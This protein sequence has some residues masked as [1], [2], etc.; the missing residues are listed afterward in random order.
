MNVHAV[1]S[2]V[3]EPHDAAKCGT[4]AVVAAA[5]AA[6]ATAA[7]ASCEE[8]CPSAARHLPDVLSVLY[9]LIPDSEQ[10]KK[11]EI[12]KSFYVLYDQFHVYAPEIRVFIWCK[13]CALLE[14]IHLCFTTK[15]PS[16]PPPGPLA[17]VEDATNPP[18]GALAGSARQE[19]T[20]FCHQQQWTQQLL[21]VSARKI[22]HRLYLA[23]ARDIGEIEEIRVHGQER[24][25]IRNHIRSLQTAMFGDE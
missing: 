2:L 25:D 13:L 14:H 9:H 10:D 5:V 17:R 1:D 12:G 18:V 16:P 7:T 19:P 4:A 20:G 8:S 22:D 11:I 24:R 6:T 21:E 3:I 15:P 23:D